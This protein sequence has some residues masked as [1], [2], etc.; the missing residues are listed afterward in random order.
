M[1]LAEKIIYFILALITTP[2]LIGAV[3][4]ILTYIMQQGGFI[5]TGK[6]VSPDLSKISIFK[7]IERLFSMRS[8]AELIKGVLK[9]IIVTTCAYF[10]INSSFREIQFAFLLDTTDVLKLALKLAIAMMI[11]ICS[12]MFII[13]AIDFLYTKIEH[14]NKLMMSMKE[15]K[16]EHKQLEGNPEIKAKLQSKRKSLLKKFVAKNVAKADVVITNPTHYAIA[17]EYDPKID[18]AP[19]VIAKGADLLAAKIREIAEQNFIPIIQNPP[20]ARALFDATE[21][22]ELIPIEYYK[23]VAEIISY[24]MKIRPGTKLAKGV[25]QDRNKK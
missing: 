13:A 22:D 16:D 6:A 8:I 25:A 2:L 14:S 5:F 9:L 3:V 7:G 18:P 11:A 4:I 1:I 10:A 20:L 17:L 15:I 12:V 24:V 23:A 19:K 21:V